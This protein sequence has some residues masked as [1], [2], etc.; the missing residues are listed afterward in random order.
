MNS[1][2]N[3]SALF[4]ITIFIFFSAPDKSQA[5]LY[6]NQAASFEGTT[7]SYITGRHDIDL[8]ITGSFTLEAWVNPANSISPSFQ[9]IF[10]K[11]LN[12]SS[13]YTLYLNQ[14]RVAVRTLG[15]TRL[16][17]NTVIPSN[18]WTH[19]AGRYNI[20]TGTFT[21]YV[22]GVS[23]SSV[24]IAGAAPTS[25]TDSLLIGKGSNDP[26]EGMMDE[27]RI[28]NRDLT[29]SEIRTY[30]RTSLAVNSGIY[31]DLVYSLTFQDDDNDGAPF[32][33]RDFSFK[34]SAAIN[35]GV[36][37]VDL[38]SRPSNTINTNDCLDLSGSSNTYLAASDH[39]QFSP[40]TQLTL[41]AWIYP[42]A[43]TNSVIIHKGLPAGG[44]GTNYRLALI[45]GSLY[46]GINGNFSYSGGLTQIPLNRWS[47]VAFTYYGGAV[48]NGQYYFYLNGNSI[49]GGAIDVGAITD[50][51]DSLYVGGTPNL[52]KF[53]GYIDEL[54]I[55]SD[56]KYPEYINDNMYRARN[57]GNNPSGET[58]YNFDG[59]LSGNC[60]FATATGQVMYFRNEAKFAHIGGVTN[61]LQSPLIGSPSSDNFQDGFL[62]KSSDRR[63]P[64]TGTS[65][66]MISDTLEILQTGSLTDIKLFIALN[67]TFEHDLR[68]SLTNPAGN[69]HIIFEDI[70]FLGRNENIVTVFDDQ[71]D[72]SLLSDRYV[73]LSPRIKALTPMIS[74]FG[75][76]AIKGKWILNISDLAAQDT[77]RLYAWG[78]QFNNLSQKPHKM[79]LSAF[80]QG[81]YNT[82][83]N[84]MVRDTMDI[85]LRNTA[86]PYN[87]VDSAKI[88]MSQSGINDVNFSNVSAGSPYFLSVEHRNMIETWSSGTVNF[89]PL[90]YQLNHSFTQD[91]TSAYGSNLI[92]VD[93]IPP[94]FACYNGD[95]DQDGLIDIADLSL[96]DND[97][98]NFNSGY[99]PTDANGDNLT[100]I[101]DYALTDNNAA[102][103]VGVITPPAP[104]PPD[105]DTEPNESINF[106]TGDPSMSNSSQYYEQ[107]QTESKNE[108]EDTR[109]MNSNYIKGGKISQED[110]DRADG[111]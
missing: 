39:A 47:H 64:A 78:M 99:I 56:V 80:V 6:W 103:F 22:N 104:P 32:V 60:G 66:L 82:F 4:I 46:A 24:T 57:R 11:R 105:G 15:T 21:V 33:M 31:E 101:A 83:T 54:V 87:K 34:N 88:Y 3:F 61:T 28:W 68:I 45:N 76:S 50:G 63:I 36:S 35:N 13:G 8:D 70:Y 58:V 25:N 42:R 20:S 93:N 55:L 77:G 14:G 73:C 1:K 108:K 41:S 65:G 5:S 10:Q 30:F 85:Y 94:T 69:T 91:V 111:K 98:F 37:G 23:D 2:F 7:G 40:T 27:I 81:F 84:S 102:N 67:H 51:T 52:T 62:I 72:S 92:S 106:F 18:Q 17:G 38:G 9:I 107:I 95:V 110:I 26:F 109:K 43:N 49:A 75:L 89:D 16:V 59:Y 12:T 86:S 44:A 96:I 90:T 29:G 48:G 79:N 74:T 19:I 100:D 53:N 71:A 97:V